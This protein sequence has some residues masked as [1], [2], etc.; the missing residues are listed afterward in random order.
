MKHKQRQTTA[1]A[2]G[3]AAEMQARDHLISKG[4]V[5]MAHR[6]K[7]PYGELDWV[8]MRGSCLIMIE[9][10]QRPT[11]D[12]GLSALTTSA[13]RRWYQAALAY[14]ASCAELSWD[15]VQ[16]DVVWVGSD[17]RLVHMPHVLSWEP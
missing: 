11:L 8:M 6:V 17:H 7:T 15:S 12:A 1:F 9:V 3:W 2:K 5:P 4:Y 14:M 16:F 10:K 13:Q